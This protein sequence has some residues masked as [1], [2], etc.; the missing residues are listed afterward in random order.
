MPSNQVAQKQSIIRQK[1]PTSAGQRHRV[2]VV[3]QTLAKH[4]PKK[5][6][7][8]SS[9]RQNGRNAQ[10]RITVRHRGGAAHKRQIR[11][12]DFKRDKDGVVARVAAIEYDPN[13]SAHLALLSYADG[14]WRYIIA[15]KNIAVGDH[16][17]SGD[18]A[19]VS[20]GNCMPLRDIPLGTIIHAVELKPGAGAKLIRS[21]GCSATLMSR[22][23]G[24]A[25]IRMRS[26][27][28]RKVREECRATV[29]EVSN[30]QHSRKKLGKA[31][32]SRWVG[33]RP[34]VRGVA[35]N[36]VDHPHG[37]GEGKTSGGGHPVSPWGLK[38]KGK[39]TRSCR[40]TDSMIIR[41]RKRK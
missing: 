25:M 7:C 24:Y 26:G 11:L 23:Q 20:P 13:R 19:S 31:G 36:P 38:T 15:A 33:K 22:E 17:M 5:S 6:L 39:K 18:S 4:G 12:V 21:A 30:A 8:V 41:S 16:L 14:E 1:R 32:R 27:E 10:G 35:M 3:T 28:V 9:R 29:G 2:D 40:R 34:T 37:G